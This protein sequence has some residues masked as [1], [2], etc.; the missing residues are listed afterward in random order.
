MNRVL[1][2]GCWHLGSVVGAALAEVG[3]EVLMWDQT[4]RV[5]DKWRLGDPPVHEPGLADLVKKL[6]RKKLTWVDGHL[7]DVSKTAQ[8]IVLAYDT[9]I[10]EQDEVQM[11]AVEEGWN[12]L[13]KAGFAFDANFLFTSQLPAGTSR[14]FRSQLLK[15]NP[16]WRGHILYTPENLRLGDALRSF[17]HPDRIVLGIDVLLS[18]INVKTKLCESFKDLIG[19]R[20]SPVHVMTLESAEMV[21]HA[22]NSFLGTCVVYANE[23]S[24]VCEKV[25]ADAWD[26]LSSLKQDVR[27]GPKAY[28]SPG[29]GFSGG[30]LARDVKTLSGFQGGDG[31]FSRLYGINA[32]RNQWVVEK[33]QSELGVGLHGKRVVLLGVTYKAFTST[34]RRSPALDIAKRLAAAGARCV[35]IDPMADLTELSSEERTQLAFEFQSSAEAAFLEADAAVVVTEWPQ[36]HELDWVK[37]GGLMKKKFVVDAKNHFGIKKL[38]QDFKRIVP[39]AVA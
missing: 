32:E 18:D 8:W 25:G 20:T 5:A 30:T 33:V 2:I 17:R 27:V 16:N 9:T 10:N 4:A 19:N 36:F 24:S 14:K 22:L 12:A 39:G 23:I 26:V 13:L 29:L 34:V 11:A 28:L 7:S 31:F 1:V 3:H 15:T 35:A 6:W 21:K 37:L 38:P